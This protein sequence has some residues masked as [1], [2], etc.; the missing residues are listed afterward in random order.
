MI[1]NILKRAWYFIIVLSTIG[2]VA[3]LYQQVSSGS[4]Y[5]LTLH[6]KSA[7]KIIENRSGMSDLRVSFNDKEIT[8]LY[9][10]KLQLKNTG[11]RAFTKDYIFEP[12]TIASTTPTRLLRADCSNNLQFIKDASVSLRW[13][14]FN[15]TEVID[16]SFFLPN[17]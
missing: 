9:L 5:S 13:D 17:L 3:G 4:D 10:T 7:D 16:C 14:L 11:K 6:L 1:K 12:L 15:P 2:G 8:S